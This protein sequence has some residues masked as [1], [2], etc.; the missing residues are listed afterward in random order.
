[1][2]RD[3]FRRLVQQAIAEI[4]PPF[5]QRLAGVAIVIRR[6]PNGGDREAAGVQRDD[7]DLFGLYTGTPLT[8][9]H[10]YHMALPDRIVI[11]QGPH[12]RAFARDAL[13][14]EVRRTVMHEVAHHFGIDD[15][16]LEELGLE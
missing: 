12:E 14:A 5:A 13:P 11:F 1:M 6:E 3:R 15:T 16:R 2:N 7:E 10:D 8:E 9:R 4:P